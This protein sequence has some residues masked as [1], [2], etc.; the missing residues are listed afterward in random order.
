MNVRKVALTVGKKVICLVTALSLEKKEKEVLLKAV[1]VSNAEKKGIC[2][3]SVPREALVVEAAA[4][5]EIV[6][7]LNAEKKATYHENVQQLVLV[8]VVEIALVSN[9]EKRVT[10]HENVRQVEA[11]VAAEAVHAST[12]EKM[13]TFLENVQILRKKGQDHLEVEEAVLASSAEKKV[14]Y[15]ENA[16]MRGLGQE[17]MS[18]LASRR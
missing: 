11:A 1:P 9:A 16:L 2:L 3:G 10:Y 12:A 14:I 15:P 4:V 8:A 18:L 5:V 7:A 17:E 6:L 13:D